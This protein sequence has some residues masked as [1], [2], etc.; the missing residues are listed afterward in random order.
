[1][2]VS[3]QDL[4]VAAK[5]VENIKNDGENYYTIKETEYKLFILIN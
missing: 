3:F 4:L 5:Q 1:V 2:V